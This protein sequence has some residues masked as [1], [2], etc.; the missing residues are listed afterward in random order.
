MGTRIAT[1]VAV[2]RNTK[3]KISPKDRLWTYQPFSQPF[4]TLTKV[5]EVMQP[6]AQA[7]YQCPTE[8]AHINTHLPEM[9]QQVLSVLKS[10]PRTHLWLQYSCVGSSVQALGSSASGLPSK[11][12]K[13]T[14][15]KKRGGDRESSQ[16]QQSAPEDEHAKLSLHSETTM[17]ERHLK[18]ND[19]PQIGWRSEKETE[20]RAIPI[21]SLLLSRN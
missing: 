20:S 4:P 3:E 1:T 2:A 17:E 8:A 21:R 18:T 5:I 10:H 19:D 6:E 12:W 9:L 11:S 16:G 7:W 15:L 14:R 13:A